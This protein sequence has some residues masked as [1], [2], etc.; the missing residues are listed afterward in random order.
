MDLDLMHHLT[1][2]AAGRSFAIPA[3]RVVEVVPPV[4]V[5][6]AAGLPEWLPGFIRYRGELVPLVDLT[7]LLDVE[8]GRGMSSSDSVPQLGQRVIVIETATGGHAGRLGLRVDAVLALVAIESCANRGWSSGAWLG[9]LVVQNADTFQLVDPD[10]ILNDSIAKRVLP[11]DVDA[12]TA[13]VVTN[14]HGT[15]ST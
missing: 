6:P 11:L 4:I 13:E 14:E 5:E 3:Q 8:D 10:A 12:V 1:F 7:R 15:R 9:P 2:T